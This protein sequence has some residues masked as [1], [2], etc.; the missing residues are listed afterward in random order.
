MVY[1]GELD[2]ALCDNYHDDL[3]F[4]HV[5]QYYEIFRGAQ[6]NEALLYDHAE[7]LNAD[8]H[9]FAHDDLHVFYEYIFLDGHALYVLA[10]EFSREHGDRVV[11]E[12]CIHKRKR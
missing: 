4:Y 5:Y 10:H 3:L 9:I 1:N 8:V 11:I 7:L 2:D 6:Y 12:I